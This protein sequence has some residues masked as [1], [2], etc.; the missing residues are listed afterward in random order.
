MKTKGSIGLT[1]GQVEVPVNFGRFVL[2][3]IEF[4]WLYVEN[5]VDANPLAIKCVPAAR[6][7]TAGQITGCTIELNGVPD[8][9][10]YVLRWGLM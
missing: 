3:P 5:T 7:L 8:T 10:N 2:E 1:I 9:G 6:I 4:D